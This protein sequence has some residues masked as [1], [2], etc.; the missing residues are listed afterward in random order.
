[1]ISS[2]KRKTGGVLLPLFNQ[3]RLRKVLW[4][5]SGTFSDRPRTRKSASASGYAVRRIHHGKKRITRGRTGGI[6]LVYGYLKFF[7]WFFLGA[8]YL[9]V[10]KRKTLRI[11]GN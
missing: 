10:K 7:V 11:G 8:Q 5:K 2:K 6:A 9:H 4:G 1:M 3:E